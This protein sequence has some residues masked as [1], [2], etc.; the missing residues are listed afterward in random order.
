MPVAVSSARA[1]RLDDL[2]TREAARIG[3]APRSPP[4]S[5]SSFVRSLSSC[6]AHHSCSPISCSSGS[7]SSVIPRLHVIALL[8]GRVG[9]RERPGAV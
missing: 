6:P 1:K 8:R 3:G 2:E 7:S 5:S 9:D 4:G